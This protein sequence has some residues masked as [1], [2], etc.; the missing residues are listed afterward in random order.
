MK[1]GVT[2]SIKRKEEKML[3]NRIK[4]SDHKPIMIHEEELKLP[5]N[6]NLDVVLIRNV[7]YFN[8]IYISRLFEEQDIPA[9]N[10]SKT[11]LEAG[12]KLF[13]NLNLDKNLETPEWNVAF[14]ENTAVEAS[15]DLSYPMVMKPVFGSWGRMVSK[16]EDK[17]TA[18]GIIE[19]R[20]S[21]KNPLHKIYYNQEYIDKP[22]RDI[23]SYVVDGEFIAASYR[24]NSDHWITNAARDG[25]ATECN[26]EDV[27]DISL[28]AW[29]AFGEGAL[30]IDIFE[31]E[32]GLLVNEVN[33]NME[34]KATQKATGIDIASE[35]IEFAIREGE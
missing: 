1:I 3:K 16:V 6:Y 5:A 22:D 28:E 32:D 31:T 8:S 34:F 26:D 24:N 20:K 9:I 12:D 27:K 29:E 30:A 13:A 7:S 4:D 18:K 19:H 10:S 17:T 11:I 21:M 2:Y 35:L 14:D 33:P 15:Q 25:K 23:R